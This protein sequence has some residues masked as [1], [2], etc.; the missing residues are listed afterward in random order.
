MRSL[1]TELTEP[2]DLGGSIAHEAGAKSARVGFTGSA[3]PRGDLSEPAAVSQRAGGLPA[4]GFPRRVQAV[5]GELANIRRAVLVLAEAQRIASAA[6]AD[7][8]L[9]VSEA[10]ANVVMH[11][12]VEA[13]EPGLLIV[14]AYRAPDALV[15]IVT[16]E[17]RGMRPR[18]D[19]PGLGVGLSLIAQLAKRVEVSDHT[20]TGTRLQMTFAIA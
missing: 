4:I 8:A 18:P 15:V 14:E 19:S 13:P 1:G 7:V 2:A 5:A 9:A 11:A 6:R 10:C 12:Y 3:E 20:P 16:D 17:G